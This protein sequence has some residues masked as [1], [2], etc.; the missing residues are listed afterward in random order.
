MEELSRL[1]PVDFLATI[2]V[3]A[4]VVPEEGKGNFKACWR[5]RVLYIHRRR[6]RMI[7]VLDP[8]GRDLLD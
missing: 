3:R 7:F 5:V 8:Q 6:F 1:P 4:M 2:F